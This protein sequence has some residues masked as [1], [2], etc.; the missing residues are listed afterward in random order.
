MWV[1]LLWSAC[2]EPIALPSS[3]PAPQTVA[4]G[5]ILEVREKTVLW[6]GKEPGPPPPEVALT[7]AQCGEFLDGGPVKGPD[8]FTGVVACGQTII[9]HT[10]GGVNRYDTRFWEAKQCW[11]GTVN[12]TSG[13]ERVYRLSLPDGKVMAT[14][15]LDTP[16]ADLDLMGFRYEGEG[17]PTVDHQV[18]QC[19]S[20][21]KPGTKR[22]KVHLVSDRPSQWVLVVEGADDAEGAFGL[23]VQ[24][25]PWY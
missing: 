8:C 25:G 20:M 2:S 4:P 3:E 21:R 14:V 19:E 18:T 9:G 13:D 22:E 11:P 24:C 1:A 23:T 7:S 16:C 6:Q 15:T 12:H 10:R 5:E 17:C